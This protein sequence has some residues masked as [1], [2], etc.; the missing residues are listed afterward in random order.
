MGTLESCGNCGRMI[1][2]LEVAHVWEG[3][4]VCAD[5]RAKLQEKSGASH[6]M[7]RTVVIL[8]VGLG[9]AVCLWSIRGHLGQD[10]RDNLIQLLSVVGGLVILFFIIA[11]AVRSGTR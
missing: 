5:C 3:H 11:A 4:V 2:A 9:G 6:R 8:A 10:V 7:P 1:G